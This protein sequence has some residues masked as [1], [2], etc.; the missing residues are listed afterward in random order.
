MIAWDR[1]RVDYL[2]GPA[3]EEIANGKIHVELRGLKL[4]GRYALVKLAKS[5]QG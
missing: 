2:E 3:E 4:R 5:R 1:G